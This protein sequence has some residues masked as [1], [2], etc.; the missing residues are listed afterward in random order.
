[1]SPSGSHDSLISLFSYMPQRKSLGYRIWIKK[2]YDSYLALPDK[3]L[4]WF[5]QSNLFSLKC[6]SSHLV[7]LF[8]FPPLFLFL[9]PF[10]FSPPSLSPPHSCSSVFS[11]A[12]S[13]V[14]TLSPFHFLSS[15]SLSS[16]HFCWT[17][18]SGIC[19]FL[20]HICPLFLSSALNN[21]WV[22]MIPV[23]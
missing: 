4:I 13:L 6:F 15:L 18:L 17:S 11:R 20:S 22:T 8:L 21:V 1:M 12:L 14:C 19:L 23:S 3:L 2:M 16:S 9:S 7:L 10:L 5:Y